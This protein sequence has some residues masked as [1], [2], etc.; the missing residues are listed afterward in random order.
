MLTARTMLGLLS[1]AVAIV[2]L[3]L[4]GT[5][6]AAMPSDVEPPALALTNL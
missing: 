1:T 4:P 6:N 3:V 2:W 5:A